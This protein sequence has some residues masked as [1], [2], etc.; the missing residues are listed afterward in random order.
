MRVYKWLLALFLSSF[1]VLIVAYVS[2]VFFVIDSHWINILSNFSGLPSSL[3]FEILESFSFLLLALG[4]ANAS[5]EKKPTISIVT[6]SAIG[7]LYVLEIFVFFHCH[8]VIGAL[9]IGSM[10]WLLAL[11]AQIKFMM[12]RMRNAVMFFPAMCWYSYLLVI[13]LE[14]ALLK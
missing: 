8:N 11:M 7:I 6:I 4:M 1:F 14:I 2:S 9:V 3:L 5:I 13:V 12:T 10:I